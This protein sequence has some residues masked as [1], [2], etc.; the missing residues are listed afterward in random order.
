MTTDAC[1]AP[2]DHLARSITLLQEELAQTNREVLMLTL[3]L[4]H[5]LDDLRVAEERYRRLAEN[6]PDIIY[7]Y[8]IRPCRRFT[9]VNSRAEAMT[10]YSAEEH[11]SDPDLYLNIVHYDDY[12][13]LRSILSGQCPDDKVAT[14]RWSHKNGST[15]WIEQRHVAVHDQSGDVIAVECVARDITERCQL[16]AQ[17]RQS[18]KMEAIG[19][20][21]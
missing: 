8:E 14:M 2:S 17:F 7:R 18:Q 3:E 6:A 1:S 11:Y 10:G 4:E 9:F 19:R 21:A 12:D 20:L 5:R 13:L 16:E 15:L